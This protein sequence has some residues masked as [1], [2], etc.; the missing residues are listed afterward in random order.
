MRRLCLAGVVLAVTFLTMVGGAWAEAPT[1]ICV[2]EHASSQVLSTNAKG[3]CPAKVIAKTT[4]KYKS[5]PLPG[6][7]E[8]EKL[9]KLLPHVNYVESGVSGKPTIQFSGVNVQ[10][11]NG[12]GKTATTNG[13]GNLVIGYDENVA[14]YSQVGSHNLVLGEEQDFGSYAGIVAGWNNQILAPFASAI[15]GGSSRATAFGATV[16]GGW[17]VLASGSYSSVSGGSDSAATTTYAAVAGGRDN[18]ASGE[19][20][21]VSGGVSSSASGQESTVTGGVENRAVGVASSVSGGEKNYAGASF[22]WVGGG[23]QNNAS[24]AWSSIFGGKQLF[25]PNN[26]EAIP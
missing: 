16:T 6:T 4:V 21:T 26:F 9:D 22:S 13:A 25:A 17:K 11:V 1:T 24:G 18:V 23:Y 12:E 3:E 19:N 8:L 7:A 2:P 14:G 5:E 15:A 10:V 20:S